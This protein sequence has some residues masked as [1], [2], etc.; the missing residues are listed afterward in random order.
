ML[1]GLDKTDICLFMRTRTVAFAAVL[2]ALAT[3]A[4][5][6]AQAD[7]GPR[8]ALTCNGSLRH[9][10]DTPV[11]LVHGTFAD[12]KINWSWNYKLTLPKL[13]YPACTVDLP[14]LS[15]GD[16]QTS[17]RYVVYAIRAM[18]RRSG[19]DIAVI[20]LSQGGLNIRWALRWWPDLRR[21]VS[22]A[23]LF[24]PPNH[25]AKFSD[26]VC[27]AP[28]VCATS[29]YQMRGDSRFLKALNR[30]REAV[31]G[32]DFTTVATADDN[33]FVTPAEA[34]LAGARNIVIQDLCPGH[35]VDHV[36]T[37]Y[38]GPTFAIALDALRHP[39]P[40][41]PRRIAD[42]CAREVMPGVTPAQAQAK[43][44]SYQSKLS[45]LLGPNGPKAPGEPP[46]ARYARP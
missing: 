20:G 19:G 13:G 16:I 23:V 37:A 45:Q 10:R 24:V 8:Q 21:L 6:A 7:R 46:L 18:A 9:A 25:G 12:S 4:P 5:A 22:D 11:L 33:V 1:T 26:D 29:L 14:H 35:R 2:A 39:G 27:T 32:P 42:P 44:A 36:G 40:A 41:K 43:V 15:A 38:D 34:R 3:L 30:G 31:P 17:S 28:G